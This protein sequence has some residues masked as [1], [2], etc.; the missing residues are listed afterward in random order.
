MPGGAVAVDV[1]SDLALELAG[2]AERV[3]VA[4]LAPPLVERLGVGLAA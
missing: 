2:T 3:Y 1:T 4:E